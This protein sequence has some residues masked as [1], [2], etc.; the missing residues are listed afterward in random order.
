VGCGPA[1]ATVA[2]TFTLVP[3][4]AAGYSQVDGV[5]PQLKAM[6][7]AEGDR[8]SA[9]E[10]TEQQLRFFDS[11]DEGLQRAFLEQTLDDAERTASVMDTL[12]TAW[13]AGDPDRI[14]DILNV[15]MKERSPRLYDRLVTRQQCCLGGSDPRFARGKRIAFH[16]CRRRPPCRPGQRPI[17]SGG[18]GNPGA[19][20]LR[21][22]S[23]C[24]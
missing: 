11:F 1:R 3:L 6:A 16:R 23:P 17:S 19:T 24:G 4:Q 5:D 15:E 9:F 7:L 2:L 13:I 20:P 14:S 8:I 12:A 18:S 22:D 10:T 21:A